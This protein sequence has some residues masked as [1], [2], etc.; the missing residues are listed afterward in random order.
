[1]RLIEYII[2][3][4]KQI[5]LDLEAFSFVKCSRR[6]V[7]WGQQ[8]PPWSLQVRNLTQFNR[9]GQQPSPDAC[10]NIVNNDLTIGHADMFPAFWDESAGTLAK[11]P[12][13]LQSRVYL[14]CETLLDDR[15]NLHSET[16]PAFVSGKTSLWFLH[17]IL[18]T[19]PKWVLTPPEKLDA[20]E[21]LALPNV[22]LRR[23]LIRRKGIEQFI[24]SMFHRVLD[25]QG[26]YT[27]LEVLLGDNTRSACKFLKMLNP[28]IGC[29]H[30][31]GVDNAVQTVEQ[32]LLWRNNNWFAHA[33]DIT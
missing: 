28:S 12:H 20:K 10:L 23:E 9:F 26:N 15:Q 11:K 2:K 32:A 14:Q 19:E 33:E 5:F 31:E 30:V 8:Q 3:M 7:P 24:D 21:I 27:L 22:D 16:K 1:M 13:R 17:G 6:G 4:N 29:W 18:I 25:V